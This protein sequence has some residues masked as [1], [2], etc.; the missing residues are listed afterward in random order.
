MQEMVEW[1]PEGM[2]VEP[3]FGFHPMEEDVNLDTLSDKDLIDLIFGE[4]VLH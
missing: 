1:C 2:S 3:Q 4:R